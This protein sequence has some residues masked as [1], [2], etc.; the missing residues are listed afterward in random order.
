MCSPRPTRCRVGRAGRA[1]VALCAG[2]RAFDPLP[3]LAFSSL[4]RMICC[5]GVLLPAVKGPR[6]KRRA[7]HGG[8]AVRALSLGCPSL[9]VPLPPTRSCVR[10]LKW[11]GMNAPTEATWGNLCAPAPLGRTARLG[12]LGTLGALSLSLGCPSVLPDPLCQRARVCEKGAGEWSGIRQ[13]GAISVHP[14][15]HPHHSLGTARSAARTRARQRVTRQLRSGPLA[16]DAPA[17]VRAR[18]QQSDR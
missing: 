9:P 17:A 13:R 4:P 10:D 18:A 2:A 3:P 12:S 1:C 8:T 15:P 5:P 16:C 6:K 14:H 11:A 7:Y